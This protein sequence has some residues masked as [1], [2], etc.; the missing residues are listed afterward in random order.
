MTAAGRARGAPDRAGPAWKDE[1]SPSRNVSTQPCYRGRGTL[2]WVQPALKSREHG[3]KSNIAASSARDKGCTEGTA[4]REPP[5]AQNPLLAG[6]GNVSG[7]LEQL[8]WLS[9]ERAQQRNLGGTT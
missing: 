9:L 1:M 4:G 6:T 2:G 3:D 5:A 8:C 7:H